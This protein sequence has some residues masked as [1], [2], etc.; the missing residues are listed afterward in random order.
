MNNY[1]KCFFHVSKDSRDKYNFEDEFYSIKGN[2][3]VADGKAA[4]ALTEKI[5]RV[6]TAEGRTEEL[7][8]A[9]QVNTLGLLHEIFHFLI[10]YYEVNENPGVLS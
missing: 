4:R 2:I 6:R 9:G 5:N 3:I 10:R 7:V 8:S 1:P